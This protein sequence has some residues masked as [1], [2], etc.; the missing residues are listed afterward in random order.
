MSEQTWP[1][2]FIVGAPKAGTTALYHYLKQHPQ[3]FMSPIKETYFFSLNFHRGV[4]KDKHK[5]LSLFKE[6]AGYPAIGEA[7]TAYLRDE[8]APFLIK[9]YVP[10]ARIIALLRDPLERAYSHFLMYVRNGRETKSFLEALRYSPHAKKYI[11]ASLYAEPI[12]RY[13]KV[14]RKDRVM[15]VMFEDLK[16][17]PREVTR[18]VV[19]FLDV[20]IE[21]VDKFDFSVPNPARIPRSSIFIPLL[22]AQK[23]IP[24]PFRAI[25]RTTKTWVL[26]T[27]TKPGRP[28]MDPRAIDFLRPI[29]ESDIEE[30]EQLLGKPLPELRRV[31]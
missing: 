26:K 15:I 20:D 23:Y 16:K 7:T 29:F 22:R 24:I 14:F 30:L 4:I 21:P 25:P 18:Q 10:R 6:A 9:R 13:W 17:D 11:T 31:W 27:L 12:K 19:R 2:F 8:V 28:P 3:I 1:N 5:Y